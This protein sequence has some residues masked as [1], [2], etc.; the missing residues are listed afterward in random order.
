MCIIRLPNL[1]HRPIPQEN[2][3]NR[4]RLM[5][6]T[7]EKTKRD[8]LL[9]T[10]LR[11]DGELTNWWV[12]AMV[13]SAKIGGS[14]GRCWTV[15]LWFICKN[16]IFLRV[17]RREKRTWN[18][19]PYA[20][21]FCQ[22]MTTFQCA[23]PQSTFPS[24]FAVAHFQ[25]ESS[26]TLTWKHVLQIIHISIHLHESSWIF[27]NPPEFAVIPA[28]RLNHEGLGLGPEIIDKLKVGS[29]VWRVTSTHRKSTLYQ[30]WR[31]QMTF[32][33]LCIESVWT[34][35]IDICWCEMTV[36]I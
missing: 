6:L 24:G 23:G 11:L 34:C 31:K 1:Q 5:A 15:D 22:S 12:K 14:L 25:F 35:D 26:R 10:M 3:R 36:Q 20:G 4:T 13:F 21:I 17:E 16:H 9:Q 2:L 30:R 28:S 33:Y 27:L 8:R 29:N 18:K 7:K 19:A 32:V